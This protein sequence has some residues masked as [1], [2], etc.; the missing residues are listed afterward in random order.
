MALNAEYMPLLISISAFFSVLLFVFCIYYYARQRASNRA[1]IEKI[2]RGGG[3]AIPTETT[4]APGTFGKQILGFLGSL[5]QR[6]GPEKSAEPPNM[7]LSFLQAGFRRKN[8]PAIFWGVKCVLMILLPACFLFI[9]ITVF[10]LM[11]PSMTLTVC[12]IMAL[13]GF[14]SPDIWLRTKIAGRREKI[15]R[16]LPDA[17]DLLV[18]CAEAGMG[19]DAAINRVAEEIRWSSKE[20][21]DELKLLNLELRAGK[22]RQDALRNLALRVDLEDLR[23]LV[24]L[25]IQTDRFGT[26]VANALRVYSD[27]LRTKR[28]QRAEE[29]AVKLPTKLIF[30]LV[31]FIFPAL[32]VAIMGPAAINI[33][34]VFLSR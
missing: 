18:V 6:V 19:L 10:K 2:K 4:H 29:M 33:Y 20:L 17:L 24:T 30:P 9:R 23:N 3:K 13:I 1:L 21:S 28:Y 31:L 25:L 15:F 22:L 27:S 8:A 26:S 11:S 5:G 12:T 7:R 14:Y 32:F 34:R 16:A